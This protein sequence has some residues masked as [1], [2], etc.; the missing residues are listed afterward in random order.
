MPIRS[1]KNDETELFFTKGRIPHRKG[2]ASISNIV[3]RKLDMLHYAKEIKDL[4]SPPQN[5][6]E[7]LTREL[8]GHYSIRINDQWRVVFKW[9]NQPYDV[10]IM[11]YH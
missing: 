10:S 8:T 11:D 3:K 7:A 9:D 6:L 1:F 4:R 5:R 2:W